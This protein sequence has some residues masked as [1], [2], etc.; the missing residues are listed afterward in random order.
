MPSDLRSLW[1][2][3]TP[4]ERDAEVA[5]AL[6]YRLYSIS[7]PNGAKFQHIYEH[8]LPD[9][10]RGKD[11]T[12]LPWTAFDA[13]EWTHDGNEDEY[14]TSMLLPYSTAWSRV[15][16]LL[17]QLAKEGWVGFLESGFAPGTVLM[18]HEDRGLEFQCSAENLPSAVALAFCLS[19]E[20]P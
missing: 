11:L 12:L 3:L 13:E 1:S 4:R 6:G 20:T 5:K 7:Y 15:G 9:C 17:H 18:A 16:A 14:E 2:S 10:A 8:P 19:R